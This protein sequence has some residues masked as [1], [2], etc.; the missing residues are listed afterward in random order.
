MEKEEIQCFELVIGLMKT[1]GEEGT[2]G[3]L[4]HLSR[5]Q[6][7]PGGYATRP[8]VKTY[9]V[10]AHED[11]ADGDVLHVELRNGIILEYILGARKIMVTRCAVDPALIAEF[12]RLRLG[13]SVW[14]E[15]RTLRC[16]HLLVPTCRSLDEWISYL[17]HWNGSINEL[18]RVLRVQ[19]EFPLDYEYEYG[20]FGANGELRLA[21]LSGSIVYDM[22][23][24]QLEVN[25][26]TSS[27]G[28]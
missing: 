10:V 7:F 5:L 4:L 23:T 27:L 2:A 8:N 14:D 18:Q 17:V 25:N 19:R 21:F 16:T 24:R 26:V 13:D 20:D 28:V 12:D 22:G 1:Y 9:H 3:L 11:N 15:Q 6:Q